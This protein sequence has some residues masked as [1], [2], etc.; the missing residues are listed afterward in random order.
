M[1]GNESTLSKREIV[2]EIEAVMEWHARLL[3]GFFYPEAGAPPPEPPACPAALSEQLQLAYQQLHDHAKRLST[4]PAQT[5]YDAVA[6]S[7]KAYIL[8]LCRLQQE[9][10]AAGAEK[11]PVTG[12]FLSE[13][14]Y[15][16]LKVEQE[17]FERKGALFSV[18]VMAVDHVP[19]LQA[20]YDSGT[21]DLV[22]AHLAQIVSKTL[23][24]F[25]DA[26][27][28]GKGEYFMTLKQVDFL[29]ACAAVDRLQ[30]EIVTTPFVL[31]EGKKVNVTVSFGIAEAIKQE[32]SDLVLVHAQE[33]LQ[34][35]QAAGGNCINEYREKS[36][37]VRFTLEHQGE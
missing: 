27:Y 18:A 16:D 32:S 21:Q 14:I 5:Q 36:K 1:A 7:L 19:E 12:L 37:L 29:D 10:P 20:R 26:Y 2:A 8:A 24:S 3:R 35:A 4:P 6:A 28:A 17:R 25:D 30:H 31:P 23:R 34:A 11:D 13:K 33:A 22:Y 9:M 15:A